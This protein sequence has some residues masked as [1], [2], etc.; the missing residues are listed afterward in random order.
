ME[1]PYL[2][3]PP[4]ALMGYLGVGLGTPLLIG[5]LLLPNTGRWWGGDFQY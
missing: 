1:Q 5:L 3:G 2:G 4:F